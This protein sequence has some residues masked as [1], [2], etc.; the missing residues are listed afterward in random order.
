MDDHC[1]GPLKVTP[2][3][4]CRPISGIAFR[5]NLQQQIEDNMDNYLQSIDEDEMNI[6]LNP[7][8][9]NVIFNQYDILI[10]NNKISDTLDQIGKDLRFEVTQHPSHIGYC[11][12][13]DN[14]FLMQ[15][16]GKLLGSAFSH[17]EKTHLIGGLICE[18]KLRCLLKVFEHELIHLAMLIF[19]PNSFEKNYNSDAGEKMDRTVGYHG[20]LFQELTNHIFNHTDTMHLIDAGEGEILLENIE[21]SNEIKPGDWIYATP[22]SPNDDTPLYYGQVEK[23]DGGDII[24]DGEDL[25][26]GKIGSFSAPKFWEFEL[27]DE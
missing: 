12:E 6:T 9:F 8:L 4:I 13:F 7:D 17:G 11:S 15:F 3:D 24:I 16:S 20:F 2:H 26:T 21:H 22:I 27:L 5:S 18:T 10:F 1:A 23:I 14:H 19:C 25:D